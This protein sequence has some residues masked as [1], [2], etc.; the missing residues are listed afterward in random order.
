MDEKTTTTTLRELIDATKAQT[1]AE[2]RVAEQQEEK[3][4]LEATRQQQEENRQKNEA[5][6]TVQFDRMLSLIQHWE[7][8]EQHPMMVIL[9]GLQQQTEILL[10]LNEV[11]ATKV[12][13]REETQQ[14]IDT[15][16]RMAKRGDLVKMDIGTHDIEFGDIAGDM[17]ARNIAGR[18]TK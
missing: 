6:R 16:I 2:Q 15:M 11:I 12:L 13:G 14:L 1:R 5:I 10:K 8:C 9:L 4:R 3:N 18:D 17:T 7:S